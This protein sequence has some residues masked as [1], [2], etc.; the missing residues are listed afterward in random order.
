MPQLGPV[1]QV[2]LQFNMY[3]LEP[4]PGCTVGAHRFAIG[5]RAVKRVFA[6]CRMQHRRRPEVCCP[7]AW[8]TPAARRWRGGWARARRP[9]QTRC[10]EP[11]TAI[12]DMQHGPSQRTKVAELHADTELA[13]HARG[14]PVVISHSCHPHIERPCGLRLQ[15]RSMHIAHA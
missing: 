15:M 4:R 14:C 2:M 8:R 6:G 10:G 12:L 1:Y 13:P 11:T 3:M 7:A 9:S 5:P